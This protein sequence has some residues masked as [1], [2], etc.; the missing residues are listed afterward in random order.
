MGRNRGFTLVELL[1]VIAIIGILIALLLPAV[2]AAREAARRT[3]CKNNLKQIG[4]ALH[5]YADSFKVFPPSSTSGIGN[6]VWNYPGAGPSDA[7]IHLHSFASLLLPYLEQENIS[8]AVNYNVSALDPVNRNIA[9]QIL[10]FYRCPSY[11]GRDYSDEPLYVTTVGYDKFAIRNYVALGA[12]TV[13][14]LSG[15]T[16]P[17]GVLFPGSKT[18]FRDVLDGTSNT[19][20]FAETRE[21]R[22][23][24][25]IDGTSAAV[26]A[27]WVDLSSPTYAGNTVSINHTPYFPGGVFPNS[28]GQAYGPSSFHPGGAQHAFVDGSVQFLKETMDATVYDALATRAGGE[29]VGEY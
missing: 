22:S 27:R 13:V 6:G 26:A 16:P 9:S 20:V 11:S 17:E 14:G 12:R 1:V 28:I 8:E 15:M 19:I 18:G 25:W 2:Q 24:V 3:Q 4:L 7:T 29:V 10:P 23:A 5:N 21:E